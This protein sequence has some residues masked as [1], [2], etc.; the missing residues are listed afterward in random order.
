M[1]KYMRQ[2]K[3]K[4]W[5]GNHNPAWRNL[6]LT[7]RNQKSKFASQ[8]RHGKDI[9]TTLLKLNSHING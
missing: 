7:A 4:F 8:I 9:T 1:T 5:F 2:H 3:K 6:C